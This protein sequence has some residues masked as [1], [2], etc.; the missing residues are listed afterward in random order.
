M[1][2]QLQFA[3]L[4]LLVDSP[5]GEGAG[6]RRRLFISV[7][8]IGAMSAATDLRRGGGEFHLFLLP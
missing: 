7:R 5:F 8:A 4:I 3:T 1:K 2:L 6:F